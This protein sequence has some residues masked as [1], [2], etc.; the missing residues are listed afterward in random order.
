MHGSGF[1]RVQS[2][3]FRILDEGKDG[4]QTPFGQVFGSRRKLNSRLT[5]ALPNPSYRRLRIPVTKGVPMLKLMSTIG[6]V[7]VLGAGLLASTASA[8]GG[9]RALQVSGTCSA[10][11]AS[12]LKAKL[13]DGRIETEAEVDQNRV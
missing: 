4:R 9:D 5:R 13:D 8:S 1:F 3:E 6:L 12:K 10:R 7:A 2:S 11:S